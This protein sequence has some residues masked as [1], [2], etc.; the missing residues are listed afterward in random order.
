MLV[1]LIVRRRFLPSP[2][3]LQVKIVLAWYQSRCRSVVVTV[4][5]EYGRLVLEVA[6]VVS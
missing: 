1:V 5:L 6:V 2:V 4:V 3:V